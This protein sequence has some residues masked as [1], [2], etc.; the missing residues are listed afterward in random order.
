MVDTALTL[1]TDALLDLGVLADE[2]LPTASQ[3]AGG[4][5]KL[6]NMLEAWNIDDLLVYSSTERVLPLVSN[7]ST[8]TIGTG[9]DLNIPRPNFITSAYV[10]DTL[11]PVDQRVD[12]PLYMFNNQEWA[13]VPFK[14][15]VT[16]Y[17][18]NGI[19][20]D[21]TF[22]LI[23]AH[24]NPVPATSQYSV[25]FWESGILTNMN[26][27][28][29]IILPP[30]YKR[31]ITSNLCLELAPSYQV[32]VPADVRDIATKSKGQLSVKNLQIN[33]LSIDPRLCGG[34]YN[35]L[36]NRYN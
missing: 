24:V 17:P 28:T 29:V 35:I 16:T 1:I 30:G 36:T 9:G 4:L 21:Q 33:E 27:N 19:W 31:A 8:Y 15:Q 23:T 5:R 22:P 11:L 3:S 6:N 13:D 2:E 32:E 34:L 25:V 14:G 7:Q 18:Y 12:I 26:I 10:R 20:F